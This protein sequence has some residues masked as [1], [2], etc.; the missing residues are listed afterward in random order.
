MRQDRPVWT[1]VWFTRLWTSCRGELTWIY[2][3]TLQSGHSQVYTN[4]DAARAYSLVTIP[5]PLLRSSLSRALRRF[6]IPFTVTEEQNP[7]LMSAL[8]PSPTILSVSFDRKPAIFR[9]DYAP[10]SRISK[11]IQQRSRKVQVRAV[12]QPPSA[13]RERWWAEEKWQDSEK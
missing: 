5:R 6:S 3:W 10:R 4:R 11:S 9:V 2:G 13:V 7:P 1:M 8:L 12:K